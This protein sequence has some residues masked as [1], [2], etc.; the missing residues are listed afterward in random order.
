M[1]GKLAV[2]NHTTSHGKH[3]IQ[4][5]PLPKNS[6][7][8]FRNKIKLMAPKSSICKMHYLNILIFIILF[9]FNFR[10][11]QLTVELRFIS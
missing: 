11:F 6:N 7:F 10:A 2:W 4:F 8:H 3:Y 9:I 5:P 1:T